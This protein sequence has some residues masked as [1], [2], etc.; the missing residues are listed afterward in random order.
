MQKFGDATV[1]SMFECQVMS[2]ERHSFSHRRLSR[3]ARMG[4]RREGGAAH[5][6]KQRR[7]PDGVRRHCHRSSSKKGREGAAGRG[8]AAHREQQRHVRDGV[9][10]RAGGGLQLLHQAPPAAAR[11][12][13]AIVAAVQGNCQ[14]GMLSGLQCWQ[15]LDG[16]SSTVVTFD[17]HNRY[18]AQSVG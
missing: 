7:V 12:L 4:R 10:R 13:Q 17:C 18:D 5:C 16:N 3:K 9:R 6:E 8:N 11:Q 14:G 2:S 1:S 15:R